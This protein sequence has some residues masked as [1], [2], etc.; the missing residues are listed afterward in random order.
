MQ[1]TGRLLT[2]MMQDDDVE[3]SLHVL[4]IRF[5]C[6][7]LSSLASESPAEVAAALHDGALPLMPTSSGCGRR[8]LASS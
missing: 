2:F 3:Y 8:F 6:V 4:C 5:L 1:L 7:A